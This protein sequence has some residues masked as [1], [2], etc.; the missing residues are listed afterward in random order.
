[1][2]IPYQNRQ[3]ELRGPRT[4]Q[5]FRKR[6]VL[7]FLAE[8]PGKGTGKDAT[9]YCYHVEKISD[10][11][12]I[13]LKRPTILNKGFD[14]EIWVERFE[15]EEDGR[16]SHEV[17]LADLEKKHQTQPGVARSFYDAIYSVY[18]TEEPD[19]VLQQMPALTF[20]SGFSPE[21]ILKVLKWMFIEQ[22][23]TY[24]NFSGRAKL[25]A[26]IDNVFKP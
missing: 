16:P 11:R 4:R 3:L 24:W 1:M 8:E 18:D 17:I 10:G 9:G 22:D 5:E 20:N 21:L 13:Y 26:A 14:F 25:K 23:L 7:E 6:L 15:R 2:K 12:R 19:R